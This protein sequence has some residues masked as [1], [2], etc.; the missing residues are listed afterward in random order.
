MK[1]I[2]LITILIIGLAAAYS[3]ADMGGHMGSRQGHMQGQGMMGQGYSSESSEYSEE[4]GPGMMGYGGYGMMGP[5]MMGGHMGGMMG[6]YGMNPCMMGGGMMGGHMGGYGMMGQGHMG[7][8]MGPGMMKGYGS[9]G[10]DPGSYKEYQEKYQKFMDDTAA[11]RKKLHTK[12]FEYR[13]A[14][15][16]PDTT[17]KSLLKLEKEMMDLQWK[18]YE[19]APE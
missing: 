13:E 4:M 5:G 15:R 7:G 8:M 12:R 18:I 11:L 1:R 2:I 9:R 10:Y 16:N 14:L 17:R 6:G 19:N 3:F